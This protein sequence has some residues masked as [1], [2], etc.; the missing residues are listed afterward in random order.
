GH[1][2]A[3]DRATQRAQDRAR[4][5]GAAGHADRQRR[6]RVLQ[7]RPRPGRV[8]H[9]RLIT[10]ADHEDAN[11]RRHTNSL[12][13]KRVFVIF[14]LS[15]LRETPSYLVAEKEQQIRAAALLALEQIHLRRRALQH[16]GPHAEPF[17][18]LVLEDEVRLALIADTPLNF[19][20]EILAA[21]L[22]EGDLRPAA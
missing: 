20:I 13:L 3:A 12:L 19:D 8:A 18:E 4:Q 16:V 7:R 2:G 5:G 22:P 14:A 6:R 21:L 11:R 10:T 1:A 9:E 17:R 15:S